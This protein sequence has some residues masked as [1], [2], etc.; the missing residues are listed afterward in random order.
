LVIGIIVTN[1]PINLIDPLGL[2]Y[3]DINGGWGWMGA[4]GTT[5][6]II[7][8]SG[9]YSYRGAGGGTWGPS[10]GLT[11]SPHTPREGW[12]GAGQAGFWGGAQWGET[13]LPNGDSEYWWEVGI[14]TPGVS[15]TAIEVDRV[16]EWPWMNNR[17]EAASDV[18]TDSK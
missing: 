9:I 8:D 4:Y 2:W 10:G 12:S 16:Y 13:T 6:I 3:I 11:W 7:G 17:E 1:N 15:I 5:G 18:C 14:V